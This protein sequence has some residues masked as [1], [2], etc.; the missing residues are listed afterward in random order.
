MPGIP[1]PFSADATDETFDEYDEYVPDSLPDPGSFLDGHDV[2][3]DDAHLGFHD[4]TR[5]LFEERGVYDMTFGYNLARLNLDRR[6]PDAGYRYAVEQESA[7][8]RSQTQEESGGPD[9][10]PVLRAEFTPTTA[11]CPQSDT[12]A[13]GSFR[14]WNG[15]SERHEYRLVRVRVDEIHHESEA[16]NEDMRELEASYLESGSVGASADASSRP[17]SGG[18]TEDGPSSGPTSPF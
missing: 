13:R 11:F 2:L 10:A 8:L 7:N 6:H 17:G 14:A 15:L 9:D 4:L 16:I 1:S 12:L 18:A 3:T 5:D